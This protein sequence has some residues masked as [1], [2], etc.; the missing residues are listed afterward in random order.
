MAY[1]I[2]TRELQHVLN[3]RSDIKLVDIVSEEEF[4]RE[5]IHRAISLPSGEIELKAMRVL[6]R[7]DLIVVYGRAKNQGQSE[8]AAEALQA[9]G[10]KHIV[11]YTDGFDG[12]K[13]A[14]LPSET[15]L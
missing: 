9:L 12:Y 2:S 15:W 3:A 4:L 7:N 14:N 13:K 11:T 8:A 10:F 6:D 5:H 1:S